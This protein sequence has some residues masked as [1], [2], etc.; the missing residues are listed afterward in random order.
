M[1]WECGRCGGVSGGRSSCRCVRISGKCGGGRCGICGGRN[2]GM[3]G[4]IIGRCRMGRW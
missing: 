2:I 1:R 3:C 4:G